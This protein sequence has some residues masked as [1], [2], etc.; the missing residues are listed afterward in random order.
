M[1]VHVQPA[2]HMHIL[3]SVILVLEFSRQ[4]TVQLLLISRQFV[5]VSIPLSFL[6]LFELVM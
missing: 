1:Y 2:Q 5:L 4:A 6:I 3:E